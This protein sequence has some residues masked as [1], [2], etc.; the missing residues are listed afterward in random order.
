MARKQG[1]EKKI[2]YRL[3]VTPETED[4][5]LASVAAHWDG[6]TWVSGRTIVSWVST[7]HGTVQVWAINESEGRGVVGHALSHMGVSEED[8]E[9][10]VTECKS[11]RFGK[12]GTM[13]ATI[14]AVRAGPRG[15]TPHTYLLGQ[16]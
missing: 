12:V 14:A 9:W 4:S 7:T 16:H 5:V 1:L 6:F 10:V 13:R 3:P 8:G 2:S 15:A 11:P